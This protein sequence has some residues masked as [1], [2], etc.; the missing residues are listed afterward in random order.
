MPKRAREREREKEC[1][2]KRKTFRRG[3]ERKCQAFAFPGQLIGHAIRMPLG[4]RGQA[5]LL[6]ASSPLSP[7]PA[8]TP[9][10][11]I[12]I[13]FRHSVATTFAS[14]R[15]RQCSGHSV[16]PDTDDERAYWTPLPPSPPLYNLQFSSFGAPLDT[17]PSLPADRPQCQ[18][19]CR[20]QAT[21]RR[22]IE[23]H[24]MSMDFIFMRTNQ[25]ILC[26]DNFRLQRNSQKHTPG[27]LT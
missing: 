15:W 19:Q 27:K 7:C 5:D 20:L 21:P 23:C 12:A 1:W 3:G 2:K 26:P 14:W 10:L 16:R 8:P 6:P 25:R 4:T 22:R 24:L 18:H 17:P 11:P 9:T 13:H